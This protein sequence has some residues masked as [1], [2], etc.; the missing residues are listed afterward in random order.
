MCWMHC[1]LINFCYHE[2]LLEMIAAREQSA[3][4]NYKQ[5][6]LSDLTKTWMIIYFSLEKYLLML[7][8]SVKNNLFSCKT[9]LSV[10][11]NRPYSFPEISLLIKVF[12]NI[13]RATKW[14]RLADLFWFFK[15]NCKIISIYKYNFKYY[16]FYFKMGN[17]NQNI[18]LICTRQLCSQQEFIII[19]MKSTNSRIKL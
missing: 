5:I 17:Y 2:R 19:A 6:C 11:Q 7:L 15:I 4:Q 14:N 9:V 16:V 3:N 1:S 13:F 8:W 18:M 12:I 10:S